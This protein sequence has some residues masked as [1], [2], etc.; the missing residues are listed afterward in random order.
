EKK[1]GI[2][3]P[4]FLYSI[5]LFSFVIIF[6]NLIPINNIPESF[7]VF[8]TSVLVFQVISMLPN[9]QSEKWFF[10][11]HN[12][13]IL[14]WSFHYINFYIILTASSPRDAPQPSELN[15]FQKK[16]SLACT[17]PLLRTAV[18]ISAGTLSKSLIKSS[19]D[20]DFKS[21]CPSTALF[22]FVTYVLWCFV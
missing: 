17:P 21:A 16:L 5:I 1:H 7:D 4:C 11:F 3:L 14:I 20:F 2:L 18:R 10:P 6:S 12:W 13:T 8:W 22:N 15:V 9:I 19:T